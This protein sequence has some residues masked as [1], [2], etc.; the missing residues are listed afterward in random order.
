MALPFHGRGILTDMGAARCRSGIA[1]GADAV[2]FIIYQHGIL[3]TGVIFD[4]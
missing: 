4:E 3:W 2:R 1:F